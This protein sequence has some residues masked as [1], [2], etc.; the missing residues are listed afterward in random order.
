M[1]T[2]ASKL[3]ELIQQARTV[4]AVGLDTEFIWERTYYPELALVQLALSNEECYLID[5]CAL[6]D[7]SP[8]GELL[9][10]PAVVKIFHDAPQD[11]MILSRAT[12]VCP[13][14]IFDTRLAA[15]FAGRPATLS[16]S[17]LLSDLLDVN[18]PKTET[19]TNWLRRPLSDKQLS[20]AL[21]D[22]RYLRAMRVLILSSL[23]DATVVSWMT[24]EL[25]KLNN[26]TTYMPGPDDLRYQKIKGAGNLKREELAILQGLSTWRE[27]E[28][29]RR[30]RPRGHIIN[31][32]IL[33]ALS[34]KPPLK[35]SDITGYGKISEKTVKYYGKQLMTIISENLERA[36]ENYP[37]SLRSAKLSA[38]DKKQLATLQEFITLKSDIAGLDP[39]LIGSNAE[40]KKLI[41]NHGQADKIACL[42]QAQGWRG[43]FLAEVL[44]TAASPLS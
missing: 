9:A 12:N 7:L 13:I 24:E 27:Q 34:K 11:L 43:T 15:G 38:E 3:K 42:R 36:P 16:L 20:Y 1:I 14:N 17:N 10:D 33:L 39:A 19:R 31:D 29:R 40:L 4:D 44:A 25:D 21:D 41:K 18:L 32:Q 35:S 37:P 26:P 2:T 6:N 5:P 28:A 30:N 23:M 22:V 8:L